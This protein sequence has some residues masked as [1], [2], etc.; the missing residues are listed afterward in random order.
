MALTWINAAIRSLC[1]EFAMR[2]GSDDL[3]SQ[4]TMVVMAALE[5]L[6]YWWTVSM[7]LGAQIV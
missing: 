5:T 7:R 4:E 1:K 6:V 2:E 3:I